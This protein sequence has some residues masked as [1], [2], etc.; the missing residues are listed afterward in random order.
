MKKTKP[1]SKI[2]RKK[3]ELATM[4]KELKIEK[5]KIREEKREKQLQLKDMPKKI[6]IEKKVPKKIKNYLEQ[7]Q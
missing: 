5:E 4:L 2:E 3:E 6:H 1:D 7:K